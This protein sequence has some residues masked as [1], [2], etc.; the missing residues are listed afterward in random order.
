MKK[1]IL[2]I[3]FLVLPFTGRAGEG[4]DERLFEAYRREDMSV[5]KEYIESLQPSAISSQTLIYEYGY[6]GYIVAEAKKEGKEALLPEAKA[7][8]QRFR[9]QIEKHK[10]HLPAGHYE[11]YRSSVYVFEL[12]LHL[13]IH[14]VKA[15]SLAKEA[16]RL[17]PQD[18]LVLSYYGTCMYYAPKPFG[19][20]EEALKWFDKADRLFR[21]PEWNYCWVKDATKMY[22]RQ[23][24]IRSMCRQ[25]IDT[26]PKATLQ[27]VYKTC[28]QDFFG[29]EHLLSDTAAARRYLHSE[30]EQCAGTE[31]SRMPASEPTG[32]RHRFIRIN[33]SEVLSGK[34][35]EQE[36]LSLFIR[37][38]SKNN[39][40]S[41]DWLSEWREIEQIA[42]SVHPEWKDETLQ[43]ALRQA[44]ESKSAVRH[45]EA[46]RKAYNPHYRIINVAGPAARDAQPTPNYCRQMLN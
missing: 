1:F 21:A 36:L 40:Y 28:F 23:C 33:L 4:F 17:A 37:A 18:P 2:F 11:M 19:S 10:S 46:F 6:C 26:Y 32:F 29:A 9:S 14:P 20:K 39:A 35:T 41:A 43:R 30:I 5:W 8:V 31:L 27:D 13:S 22:I 42:L 38:A 16:T 3:A 25:M 45:S 7:C 15:M 12:R 44:A 34:M 24:H